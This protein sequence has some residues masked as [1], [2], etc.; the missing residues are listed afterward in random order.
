MKEEMEELSNSAEAI[1]TELLTVSTR[2][3]GVKTSQSCECCSS[4]LFGKQF[5]LF[6]C[7]HGFHEDCLLFHST[8]YLDSE[9]EVCVVLYISCESAVAIVVLF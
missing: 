5:Y 3:F 8:E 7:G 2:G 9:A 6:P 1:E 4:A